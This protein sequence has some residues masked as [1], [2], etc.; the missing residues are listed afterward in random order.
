MRLVE[1]ESKAPPTP[2][3][4]RGLLYDVFRLLEEFLESSGKKL[5]LRAKVEVAAQLYEM[6]IEKEENES[7]K[8][9]QMLRVI[10]DF[11]DKTA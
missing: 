9:I 3:I 7:A 2:H 6:V 8:S 1:E 5:D 4:D 10:N 11:L